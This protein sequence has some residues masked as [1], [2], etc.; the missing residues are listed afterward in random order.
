VGAISV[1]VVDDH[2]VFAQALEA[3]LAREPALG[4]VWV[5]YRADEAL[6]MA[7]R[8][9]PDVVVLDLALGEASGL[10]V[11]REIRERLPATRVVVLTGLTSARPV[12]A[13]LRLGVRAWL[14]KTVD[15]DH[16]VRVVRGVAAGEAWLDPELLG[17]VLTELVDPPADPP[18]D[19]LTGLTAREREVLGYLVEGLSR[20]EIAARLRVSTNTVRTHTQNL[21]AKLD[22][23]T[24]L[25]AVALVLRQR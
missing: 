25:E 5:A 8:Y 9:R 1:L 24:S 13:G 16:L 3:R 18:P 6:T 7:D 14:S 15:A 12:V 4:P 19:P 2:P 21:M 10:D 11:A 20:R 22:V 23:H 17:R